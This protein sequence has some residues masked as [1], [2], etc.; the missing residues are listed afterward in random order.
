[1]SENIYELMYMSRMGDEYAF[2][3]LLN[4]FQVQINTEVEIV[5][6]K[7][8][9][10]RCYEEDLKQEALIVVP[11]ALDAYREDKQCGVITFVYLVI[12]RRIHTSMRRYFALSRVHLMNSVS[13][14]SYIEE[15]GGSYYLQSIEEERNNPAFLVRYNDAIRRVEEAN[16]KLSPSDQQVLTMWLSGMTYQNAS[17]IL[18][19]SYKTYDA[20]LQRIKKKVKKAIYDSE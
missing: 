1:M 3:A 12:R 17:S 10:L 19:M 2:K 5:I 14:S 20:K 13:Y 8:R 7:Y 16:L 18:G 9:S 15:N 4:F 11:D 6:S